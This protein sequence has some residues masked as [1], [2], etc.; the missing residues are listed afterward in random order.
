[1]HGTVDIGTV[2]SRKMDERG[3]GGGRNGMGGRK[4]DE[5]EWAVLIEFGHDLTEGCECAGSPLPPLKHLF[6]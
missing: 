4:N 5:E 1:M 2:D 3:F 6:S